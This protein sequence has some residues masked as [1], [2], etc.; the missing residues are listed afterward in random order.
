NSFK[1]KEGRFRLDIRETF[2]VMRVVKHW[3]GLPREPVDAPSL[4]T[5]KV[6]LDVSLSN[7]I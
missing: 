5:F 7:L 2:F 3:H 4:E 1:L 6:R